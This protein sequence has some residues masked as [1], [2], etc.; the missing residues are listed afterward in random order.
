MVYISVFHDI[1]IC[2]SWNT[3]IHYQLHIS[4]N[5]FLIKS[6]PLERSIKE[7]NFFLR[8]ILME[9]FPFESKLK[10][11]LEQSLKCVIY[12]SIFQR[13]WTNTMA[14]E[15]GRHCVVPP[16][17]KA[18]KN[19]DGTKVFK[20]KFKKE[21]M[22]EFPVSQQTGMAAHFIV[23]LVKR[24]SLVVTKVLAVSNSIWNPLPISIWQK[25]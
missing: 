13:S 2:V 9:W 18:K 19:F 5:T 3:L 8:S 15:S 12:L 16:A 14:S 6:L 23:Y 21:W 10:S 25:Q 1:L 20:S 17:E 11:K 4:W 7:N 24:M 22:K